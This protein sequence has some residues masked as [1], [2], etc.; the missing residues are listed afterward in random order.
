LLRFAVTR[1]PTPE[2]LAHQIAEAIPWDHAPKY[3]ARDDDQA[4]GSVFTRRIQAMGIR[5]QPTSFRLLSQN[6]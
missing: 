3:I 4:F 1:H 5:D 2:R 6:G